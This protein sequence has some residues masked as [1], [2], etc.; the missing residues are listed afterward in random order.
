LLIEQDVVVSF[1]TRRP[2]VWGAR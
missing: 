2:T 1:S